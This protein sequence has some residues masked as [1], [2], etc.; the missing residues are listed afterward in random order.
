MKFNIT[1]THNE[2]IIEV[3]LPVLTKDP[4]TRVDSNRIILK[5]SHVLE[6]LK[7]KGISVGSCLQSSQID[8]M[9]T[10]LVAVW[11]Y[12][13]PQPKK[14]DITPKPVVSSNKAKRTK[15]VI[16]AKDE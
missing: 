6:H 9:G 1:Q 8:N 5:P 4:I 2:V 12:A 15:K 7:S 13:K 10:Q 16:K 3:I 11:K 14:L